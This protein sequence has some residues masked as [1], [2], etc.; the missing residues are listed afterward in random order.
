MAIVI[1]ERAISGA[2]LRK[3]C[4]AVYISDVLVHL[5]TRQVLRGSHNIGR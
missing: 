1:G 2:M 4:A 5:I 3:I